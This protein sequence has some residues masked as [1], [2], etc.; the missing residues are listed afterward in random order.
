MKQSKSDYVSK[1][2]Y[3]QDKSDTLEKQKKSIN[4]HHKSILKQREV[5]LL[6][7]FCLL[8]L[9]L[10]FLLVVVSCCFN[11]LPLCVKRKRQALSIPDKSTNYWHHMPRRRSVVCVCLSMCL[12]LC[13]F[14]YLASCVCVCVCVLF[15]CFCVSVVMSLS[16][17]NVLFLVCGQSRERRVVCMGKSSRN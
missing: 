3:W 5:I 7:L 11:F 17:L 1:L 13:V 6:R 10:V 12:W 8:L 15:V 2:T 9:F 16:C 14:V 4:E